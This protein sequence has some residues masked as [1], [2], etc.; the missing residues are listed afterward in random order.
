MIRAPQRGHSF[1]FLTPGPWL[2]LPHSQT[3]AV[4][5]INCRTANRRASRILQLDCFAVGLLLLLPWLFLLE[6]DSGPRC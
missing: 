4:I 3:M 2:V 1:H 6:L 5:L